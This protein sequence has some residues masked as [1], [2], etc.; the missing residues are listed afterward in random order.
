MNV[1]QATRRNEVESVRAFIDDLR[2]TAGDDSVRAFVNELDWG[3]N[4]LIQIACMLRCKETCIYLLQAGA[5]A[6]IKDG[7]GKT[8]FSYIKDPLERAELEILAEKYSPNFVDNE[9]EGNF[10]SR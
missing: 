4:T 6:S 1:W 3:G 10:Y 5:D 7:V 9:D 8:A 2:S